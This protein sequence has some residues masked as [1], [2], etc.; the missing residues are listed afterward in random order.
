M[1]TLYFFLALFLTTSLVAQESVIFGKVLDDAGAA[2]PGAYVSISQ[3]ETELKAV[4]TDTDGRFRLEEVPVGTYLVRVKY[5]GFEDIEETVDLT[6]KPVYMGS[7]KMTQAAL[8]LDEVKVV[9]EVLPAI[10][11]GDTTEFNAGAYK[12]L[13]DASAEDLLS[14][15]PTMV[16]Q[17]GK[18]QAQGEDVK[19]VLVDGRPFFGNDPTAALRNL[20]AEVIEKIQVFDQQ[21]DQSQFT[22]FNDGNTSKTIN[23]VTRSGM[24][25]GQFGKVY[26]GYGY[27]DKYKLGF[28]GNLFDGN[29]R[30]SVIGLSN[31]INEQNFSAEDLLGVLGSGGQR[32]RGGFRGGGGGGNG[33]GGGGGDFLVDQQGGIAKTNSLGLNYT[34]MWGKKFDISGSYFVNSSN[35]DADEKINR[36]YFESNGSNQV[37][38]EQ[39]TSNTVNTNHRL[40][41]RIEYQIDS[42]NSIIMRPRLTLQQNRGTS[43]TFGQTLLSDMLLNQTD[44]YY[45]SDLT[46]LN[47]NNNLL[48][49]HRFAKP[50][51]TMSVNV[52]GGY[53]PKNGNSLLQ[54]ENLYFGNAPSSEVLNQKALLETN[55]WNIATSLN[56]TE[57]VGQNSMLMLDYR[58]SLQQE[59]SDRETFDYSDVTGDYDEINEPLTNIFSN[60]YITNSLG[61]GYNFRKGRD[62]MVMARANVQWASLVNEE[63]FP[64]NFNFKQTYTNILPFVM[65]RY[66]SR[67]TSNVSLFYRTSTQLPSVDQLQNVVD[68]TNPL[69]LTIGNP[70]L[71]QAYQHNVSLR[72]SKTSTGSSSVFY[73]YV[74]GGFTENYIA[75]S[76]YLA[77]S[78]DPIFA[79]LDVQ[80]G[81]QLT[82]P[83]NLDG[84][85]NMRAFITY[86]L[87]VK[88]LK[89][90]LN[91]NLSTSYSSVP[92]LINEERN[93]SDTRSVGVGLVLASNVSEK[94]DFTLSL[95]PSF[96]RTTN[97]LQSGVDNSY[98]SQ[99]S[100]FQLGWVFGKDF[101]L[102]TNIA[103][104]FYNGLSEGF[105]QNY[106]L[107]GGSLGK[108][109][110]KNRLGE[111]SLSMFDILGQNQSIQRN[112]TEIYLEDVQTQVLQRYVMLNLTY[113]FRN[114]STGRQS[115]QRQQRRDFRDGPP[116]FGR[117]D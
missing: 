27:E 23:I 35:T 7:L 110:F 1:K 76:T 45:N 14:K 3:Q 99:N 29:R 69:Q 108:K 109:I 105:D 50:R 83:T 6:A 89:S 67:Q 90:N 114:W 32:G 52:S 111:I 80:P 60:D 103:H 8:S 88:F 21:S 39:S 57:P 30:I 54:S 17:N 91:L 26:G 51:R 112:V 59:E 56:Y 44:N 42:V 97:S 92:G 96:N 40:N 11:K 4:V 38:D 48:F 47:F 25:N 81:A 20:P 12:T 75:K 113:Q 116:P 10:Q 15:M 71:R 85:W 87:P 101:V 95:R 82:Q 13:K 49:R 58:I 31:N 94:L 93:T 18:V 22:G 36:Q 41:F 79:D 53:A 37:Y 55:N 65:L 61:G 5:L 43:E 16:I 66:G 28:S 102:R 68:N 117:F 70:N 78:D 74:S 106:W 9:G 84:Y 104:Q 2:L 86:G 34:D 33:G 46:G 77:D 72:Y 64:D 115:Q 63:T 100:G 62:F 98:Y 73:A 19:E 107:W 24:N